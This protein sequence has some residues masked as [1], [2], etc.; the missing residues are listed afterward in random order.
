MWV[1]VAAIVLLFIGMQVVLQ[2][3]RLSDEHSAGLPSGSLLGFVVPLMLLLNLLAFDF[4]WSPRVTLVMR[5]TA[6]VWLIF[7][8]LYIC[9]RRKVFRRLGM[10]TF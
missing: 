10:T 1:C 4:R 5:V 6:W 9:M 7:G 3:R 8:C 2:V